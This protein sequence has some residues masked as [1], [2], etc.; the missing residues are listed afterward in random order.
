M[1]ANLRRLIS[2]TIIILVL[3]LAPALT[4]CSL[5]LCPALCHY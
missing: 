2:A 1:K 5:H 4:A 3:A